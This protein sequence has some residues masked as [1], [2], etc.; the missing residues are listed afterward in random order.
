MGYYDQNDQTRH[1][2]G[3]GR[4][5]SFFLS[6]LAG[7]LI[8]AL[9]II[10]TAPALSS[11]GVLPYKIQPPSQ[12]AAENKSVPPQNNLAVQSLSDKEVDSETVHA[13]EK[14]GGAVVGITNIQ[15]SGFWSDTA[16]EQA[17]GTGSGVIYKKAGDK[18]FVVT[19][20][21]VV[22]GATKL[23]VTL[24][25]GTKIPAKLLGTDVL[26]D[27]AVLAIDG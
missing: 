6:S 25:N 1:K 14:A 17:A 9:I 18:A 15:S 22:E 10:L 8:G 26:T 12:Q 7:A 2:E 11:Y 20:N 4:K 24:S 23:E 5:G 3:K 13:V 27:L 19:N 21:H 16:K